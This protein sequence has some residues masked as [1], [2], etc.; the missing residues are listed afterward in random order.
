MPLATGQ[1]EGT[2]PA[3]VTIEV[4]TARKSQGDRPGR[5]DFVWKMQQEVLFPRVV[6]LSL[7]WKT[8]TLCCLLKACSAA[9]ARTEGD[10]SSGSQQ[11]F[12]YR[13]PRARRARLLDRSGNALLDRQDGERFV[14]LGLVP[15]GHR[16]V[17]VAALVG[18]AML[19]GD[20]DGLLE[21][22]GVF[23]VEPVVAYLPAPVLSPT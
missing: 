22:H 9:L 16:G 18:V 11:P 2:V 8:P 6:Q 1:T 19:D 12:A 13:D 10:S 20:P 7:F 17:V 3:P 5:N 4:E 15:V 21:R 23:D 14:W